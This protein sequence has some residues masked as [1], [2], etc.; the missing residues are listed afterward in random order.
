MQ[1]L[2]FFFFFFDL[3]DDLKLNAKKIKYDWHKD[4]SRAI[5]VYITFFSF[6]YIK[7]GLSAWHYSPVDVGL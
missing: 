2:P 4:D 3:L 1:F 7:I 5:T 6:M